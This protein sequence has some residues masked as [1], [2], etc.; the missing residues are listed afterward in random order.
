MSP[1]LP[2]PQGGG[3]ACFGVALWSN[4]PVVLPIKRLEVGSV[5]LLLLPFATN[6]K[7][8]ACLQLALACPVPLLL[9]PCLRILF[10]PNSIPAGRLAVKIWTLTI[11]TRNKSYHFQQMQAGSLC[12]VNHY[13]SLQYFC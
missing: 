12:C 4:L 6:A 11:H 13:K 8:S 1:P 10:L 2:D 7:G 5:C 9:K 3:Q